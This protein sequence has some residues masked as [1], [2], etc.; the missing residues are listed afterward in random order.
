MICWPKKLTWYLLNHGHNLNYLNRLRL[1][2]RL[3]L[4]I[5]FWSLKNY[6]K[7]VIIFF[8]ALQPNPVKQSMSFFA[9]P[10]PLWACVEP[11]EMPGVSSYAK[12]WQWIV[13]NETRIGKVKNHRILVITLTFVCRLQ[14]SLI[15]TVCMHFIFVY[16]WFLPSRGQWMDLIRPNFARWGSYTFAPL[17]DHMFLRPDPAIEQPHLRDLKLINDKFLCWRTARMLVLYIYI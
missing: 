1:R 14:Q 5:K 3:R 7:Y 6:H 16:R 2:L 4:K 11:R 10:H 15:T 8:T 17:L 13:L 12:K 9:L